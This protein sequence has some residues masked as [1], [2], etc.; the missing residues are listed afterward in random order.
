MGVY[1]RISSYGMYL[2]NFSTI[3]LNLY[4]NEVT[5]IEEVNE[6]VNEIKVLVLKENVL[7]RVSFEPLARTENM[8]Y[9]LNVL[10]ETYYLTDIVKIRKK[11]SYCP[12]DSEK[13]PDSLEVKIYFKNGDQIKVVANSKNQHGDGYGFSFNAD[14]YSDLKSFIGL[15]E[16]KN[17]L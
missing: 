11:F 5:C 1:E 8:S 13:E 10:C 4:G 7:E 15:L 3:L 14:H 9:P 6:D 16:E 12:I 17:R 2:N